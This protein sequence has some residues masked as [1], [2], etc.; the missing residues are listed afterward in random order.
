MVTENSSSPEQV[1]AADQ[2]IKTFRDFWHRPRVQAVRGISFEVRRGEVFGLL[3]P[4]GSGKSTT[5]K[6][7]LGLLHPS[8]G[9]LNV[10]GHSPR[11]VKTK[12]RMGYL[13]EESYIY[14]Y[15]T[16]KETLDFYGRLFD[17]DR[18][19]RRRRMEE[20]LDMIGLSHARHRAVGEFSKG[21]ARRVGLAQA[22]IND[23]DLI[24][25]D[26]PTS[27]LD[28]QGCRQIKDLILTLARRGKTVLLSSHLLADVEDVCDRIAI[29]YNGRIQAQGA[30]RNLLEQQDLHRFTIPDIPAPQ[31]QKLL[32]ALREVLGREPELDHPRRN[33]EQ[34]FIDVIEQAK[35]S[36]PDPSGVTPSGRV[37]E[38]LSS[39]TNP[40]PPS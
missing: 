32:V 33:L 15:L 29:L 27:G 22:L 1:I 12:A 5:L 20:L 6:M 31:M 9:A 18:S 37:A 2:L 14:P 3:G 36:A 17:L 26:E 28:P 16:P 13:P 4:N 21:M 10:L 30:I 24:V 25:L 34:Y 40:Q 11:D 8:S 39:E 19:E 35:Q 23:P 7:I 38:Y